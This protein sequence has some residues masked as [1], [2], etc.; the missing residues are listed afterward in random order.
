MSKTKVKKYKDVIFLMWLMMT[1]T[2]SALGYLA[3]QDIEYAMS[4]AELLEHLQI[5]LNSSFS[6]LA[7]SCSAWIETVGSYTCFGN[8]TNGHLE[9][10]SDSNDT[11]IIDYAINN[12][13]SG[14]GDVL[15]KTGSYSASITL[16]DNVT[17]T[18]MRGVSGVSVSIDSGA[19][20]T[21]IDEENGYRKE[22]VSGSLYSFMDWRA[23]EFWYAGENR[24][25]LI[26]NPTSE[27][28][29]IVETDGTDTWMTN[30]STG[31]RDATSTN[32][33]EIINWALGNLT[34]GRTWYEKVV[35]K[36]NFTI[37]SKIEIPDYTTFDFSQAKITRANSQDDV[38]LCNEDTTNGG[39]YITIIGGWLDGN[40]ANNK[41]NGG[42]TTG[43]NIT[44]AIW[45]WCPAG[46]THERV[47]ISG[48]HT[49]NT[50]GHAIY[51]QCP[52]V[53]RIHDCDLRVGSVDS[54]SYSCAIRLVTA[55]DMYV[56]DIDL[57]GK[58]AAIYA[59]GGFTKNQLN[60]IMIGGVDYKYGIHIE[61]SMY[62]SRIDNIVM[63]ELHD[64]GIV[65]NG[66]KCE[67]STICGIEIS[68]ASYGT[69]NTYDGMR[70]FNVRLCN[71]Y[72]IKIY[73][74]SQTEQVRYGLYEDASCS[75]NTYSMINTYDAATIGI[76]L[77]GTNSHICC[78]WN[79]TSWIDNYS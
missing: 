4:Q 27:A 21:L 22:Y 79:G 76:V 77:N 56:N 36:G 39:D 19:D 47:D 8:G 71:I 14:G 52:N 38:M 54:I 25:D 23:G 40:D 17:L 51:M 5:E 33:S 60:D 65:I 32:A 67:N 69:N 74:S 50:R 42:G 45:F 37:D 70:L 72:D 16:K 26:V 63:D 66:T 35:L 6:L 13:T 46:Q 61:A 31:Q 1:T 64:H 12:V 48:V 3:P 15:V 73:R 41:G 59:T 29:Y 53:V 43:A 28:S 10:Y 9:A 58:Y 78:S 44:S 49:R 11:L 34:S 20:C 62:N 75:L 57:I 18:L 7:K 68:D 55:S 30:C 2:L 24:T